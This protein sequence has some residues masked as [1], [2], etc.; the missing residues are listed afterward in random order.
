MVSYIGDSVTLEKMETLGGERIVQYRAYGVIQNNEEKQDVYFKVIMDTD[1]LT[2][3]ITPYEECKSLD[4]IELVETNTEIKENSNNTFTYD[5]V[6][7]E[8]MSR[9]YLEYYYNLELNNQNKAYSLI[10]EEYKKERFDSLESYIDYA[11]SNKKTFT[12]AIL[13]G[14]AVEDNDEYT[15]YVIRDSY[16]NYYIIKEEAI[17][18]F[19]I[20]LD[21]YTLRGDDYAQSYNKLSE[22]EKASADV[23]LFIQMIN[24]RDY[25]HAYNVLPSG[26]KENYFQTLESFKEYISNNY[27]YYNIA[28]ISST[29]NEGNIYIYTVTIKN[30]GSTAAETKDVGFNVKLGQDTD[31]EISFNV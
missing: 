5:E 29:K 21:T 15:Q 1:N 23:Q 26:F 10:D 17:M 16:E 31:F 19:T 18:N 3:S 30:G 24:N 27:Y 8:E 13:T 25:Q 22:S 11:N 14:Y 7:K 12:D 4:E 2:F 9:R 20:M 28:T 6:N